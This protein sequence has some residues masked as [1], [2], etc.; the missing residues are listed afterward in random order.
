MYPAIEVHFNE[1][2]MQYCTIFELH[3][4]LSFSCTSFPCLFFLSKVPTPSNVATYSIILSGPCNTTESRAM[5]LT[6][7]PL[8]GVLRPLSISRHDCKSFL[9]IHYIKY[10]GHCQ[11]M[12][13]KYNGSFPKRIKLGGK[14]YCTKRGSVLR[15]KEKRWGKMVEAGSLDCY[16]INLPLFQLNKG[17]IMKMKV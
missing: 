3:L 1:N 14:K 2:I 4:N 8:K 10:Y 9:F 6:I 5:P 15:K 11:K 12:H 16:E 7:C 13:S 17:V